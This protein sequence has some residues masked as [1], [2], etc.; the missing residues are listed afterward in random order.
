MRPS[1]GQEGKSLWTLTVAA[2]AGQLRVVPVWQALQQCGVRAKKTRA[3]RDGR[4]NV[5]ELTIALE[6]D[7]SCVREAVLARLRAQQWITS[8][9]IDDARDASAV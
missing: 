8:V 4:R 3:H 6:A 1:S 2:R 9:S 5:D 7:T